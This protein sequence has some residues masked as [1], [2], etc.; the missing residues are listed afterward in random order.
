MNILTCGVFD[1]LHISHTDF[2]NKIKK[3][4]DNLIVLIH[5]DRFVS[6]YKRIPIINENQRML[7]ISNL[8]NVDKTFV[9][10][11]EYLTQEIIN[12][13]QIKKVFQGTD[14]KNV[15]N[16]Y[17]HIPIKLNIMNFIEYNTNSIS[18]TQI[19]NNIT[20]INLSED[21][22]RYS[23]ENILKNELLYGYGFQSPNI[24]NIILDYLPKKKINTILEIG[25]G[26][27]GNCFLLNNLYNCDIL[28]IDICKNMIDICI[29]RNTKKNITFLLKNYLEY[30]MVKKYNIIFVRDV[31]M[32]L[33]TELK[34]TY[35]NKIYQ[36]LNN[37]GICIIIDYCIGV[38]KNN[39]F[40]EYCMKRQ[41]KIIDVLLYKKL[42]SDLGFNIIKDI[43]LSNNYID[44]F[45]NFNK[46]IDN[47]ILNNLK[48]KIDFF[49]AK[50]LSWHL[51]IISKN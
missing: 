42:I 4:G 44:Y 45:K 26:L 2:L 17:Y 36:D 29:E 18:T 46:D 20:N 9:D 41:W 22:L 28:G 12:K 19:I 35:L 1:L 43:D 16:Y 47:N 38:S 33:H 39:S 30:K 3:K 25:C 27:G 31:F 23:K 51:F 40:T 7:M 6:S 5:S 34:Y 8:K 14:N 32:Y 49:E 24:S 10:D 21:N 13:Y 15:W 11:S 37:D 50:N 48:Q